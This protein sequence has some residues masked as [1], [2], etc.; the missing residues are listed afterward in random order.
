[1]HYPVCLLV[2]TL[3]ERFVPHAPGIQLFGMLLAWIASISVGALFYRH[4]ECRAQRLLA[5]KA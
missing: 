3:F 1:M 2:N 4:V 5:Q